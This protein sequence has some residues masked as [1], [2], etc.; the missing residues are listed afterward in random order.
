MD[1]KTSIEDALAKAVI[2][3]ERK[4]G[5]AQIRQMI[6]LTIELVLS[7]LRNIVVGEKPLEFAAPSGLTLTIAM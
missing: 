5:E 7:I 2:Q 3:A 6:S 1:S 4:A